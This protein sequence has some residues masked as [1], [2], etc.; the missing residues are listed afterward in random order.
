MAMATATVRISPVASRA[1]CLATD[2]EWL[3]ATRMGSSAS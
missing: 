2:P 1:E 3:E